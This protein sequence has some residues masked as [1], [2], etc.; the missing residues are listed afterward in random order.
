MIEHLIRAPEMAA[1]DFLPDN[2][3]LL[4]LE[5]NRHGFNLRRCV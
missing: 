1:A 3:L 2:P 5:V 4:G